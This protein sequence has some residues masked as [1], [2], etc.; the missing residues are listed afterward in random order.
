MSLRCRICHVELKNNDIVVLDDFSVFSH[1]RCY[2]FE[3]LWPLVDSIGKFKC[4]KGKLS[5][6]TLN[7]Y[8]EVIAMDDKRLP[9][10]ISDEEI[11]EILA[12]TFNHTD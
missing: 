6:F 3:K 2:D 8:K 4:L 1:K 11:Y 10:E 9:E 12:F 7:A 5:R